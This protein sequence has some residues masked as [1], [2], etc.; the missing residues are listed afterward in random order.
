ML[1]TVIVPTELLVKQILR[2]LH[3]T[4]MVSDKINTLRGGDQRT[5]INQTYL[6]NFS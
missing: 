1:I 3:N 4:L 5:E 6:Y 2:V